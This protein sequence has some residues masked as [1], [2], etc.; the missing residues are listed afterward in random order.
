[1]EAGGRVGEVGPTLLG[2]V[3][4]FPCDGG[5]ALFE[6]LCFYQIDWPKKNRTWPDSLFTSL[7]YQVRVRVPATV[8]V[9]IAGTSTVPSTV[10][11]L[12]RIANNL[13]KC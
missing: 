12:K 8:P 5:M 13:M 10:H 2:R 4:P 7:W 9:S 3:C 11:I 6:G 1:M